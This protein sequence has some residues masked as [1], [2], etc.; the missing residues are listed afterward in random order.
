MQTGGWEESRIW[1]GSLFNITAQL[2]HPY[3]LESPGD[4][5]TL[6]T[7]NTLSDEDFR[8]VYILPT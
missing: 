6:D 1:F 2:F 8:M 5:S 7:K 4:K 3:M